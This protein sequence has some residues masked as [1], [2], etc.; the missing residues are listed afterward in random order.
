MLSARDIKHTLTGC[1]SRLS[2]LSGL[3][4][5]PS[6]MTIVPPQYTQSGSVEVLLA[7]A[8]GSVVVVDERKA[9]DQVPSS[10]TAAA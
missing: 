6:S 1:C 8:S 2:S 10:A 4:K 5:P 7:T 3:N 9:Q